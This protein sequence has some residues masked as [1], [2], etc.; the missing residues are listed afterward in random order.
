[1]WFPDTVDFGIVTVFVN[2][3]VEDAFTV[4]RAVLSREIVTVSPARN[5]DPVSTS[6]PPG[7]TFVEDT[8]K[9]AVTAYAAPAAA[10][11]IHSQRTVTRLQM[12]ILMLC[13]S[14]RSTDAPLSR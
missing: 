3:P 8:F 4:A 5:P 14:I 13:C 10:S 6:R 11:V 1:V 2:V 7:A 9:V 12:L